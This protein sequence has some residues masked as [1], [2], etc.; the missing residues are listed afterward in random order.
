MT[1]NNEKRKKQQQHSIPEQKQTQRTVFI[2][3]WRGTERIDSFW[4]PFVVQSI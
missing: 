1:G 4:Q 2:G 3:L